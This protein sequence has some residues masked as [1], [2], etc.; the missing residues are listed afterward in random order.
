MGGRE[1][2]DTLSMVYLTSTTATELTR[3]KEVGTAVYSCISSHS[4]FRPT[5]QTGSCGRAQPLKPLYRRYYTVISD[6][7]GMDFEASLVCLESKS[8]KL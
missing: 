5:N 2:A 6:H 8:C 1:S 7:V 3:P 4:M